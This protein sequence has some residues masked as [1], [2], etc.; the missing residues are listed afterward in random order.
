M[1][2]LEKKIAILEQIIEDLEGYAYVYVARGFT[3][4]EEVAVLKEMLSEL[5]RELKDD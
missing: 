3:L 5:K 4:E 1:T 2:E